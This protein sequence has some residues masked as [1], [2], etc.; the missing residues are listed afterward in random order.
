[1]D[2]YSSLPACDAQSESVSLCLLPSF[3]SILHTHLPHPPQ[4]L[5]QDLHR[6]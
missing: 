5:S 3:L 1:M 2:S 6:T 4:T